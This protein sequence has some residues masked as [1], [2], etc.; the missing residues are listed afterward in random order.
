MKKKILVVEDQLYIGEL[1]KKIL[2]ENGYDP[3][4]EVITSGEE[5]IKSIS[6]IRP[7]LILMDIRLEDGGGEMDGIE[8][9]KYINSNYNIPVIYLTAYDDEETLNRA[10]LT[11]PFGYIVKPIENNRDII[12]TIE[13]GLHNHEIKSKLKQMEQK[14]SQ[15]ER[16]VGNKFAIEEKDKNE[17]IKDSDILLKVKTILSDNK[18]TDLANSYLNKLDF[19]FSSISNIE[20]LKILSLLNTKASKFEEILN[21]IKK[22]KSTVSHHLR[23][24]ENCNLISIKKDSEDRK[25]Q[26]YSFNNVDPLSNLLSSIPLE[27]LAKM[28]EIFAQ[29]ERLIMINSMLIEPINS[30]SF[31]KMLNLT[32]STI[33]HHIKKFEEQNFITGV[34]KGKVINYTIN[35]EKL[36]DFFKLI[37]HIDYSKIIIP[38]ETLANLKLLE[39]ISDN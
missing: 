24:L 20:R 17:N 18:K 25:F 27:K 30:N 12:P 8:T 14:Y 13:I 5:V 26:I 38:P 19:F 34:K 28:F 39:S 6:T 21:Y 11:E 4:D 9:A 35:K 32:P 15:I 36:N 33:S 22:S 23:S 16:L 31:Q 3:I 2:Q 10:K 7:D 37:I 29:K 1:I